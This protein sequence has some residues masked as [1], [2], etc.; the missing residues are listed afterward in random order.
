L[1]S[2]KFQLDYFAGIGYANPGIFFSG[3]KAIK[4]CAPTY[5]FWPGRLFG[6]ERSAAETDTVMAR[7]DRLRGF[8]NILTNSGGI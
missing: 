3:K 1:G 5:L 6:N 7:C 2:K 4:N 8:W